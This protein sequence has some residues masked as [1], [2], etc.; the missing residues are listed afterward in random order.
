MTARSLPMPLPC[1]ETHLR[2]QHATSPHRAT[3]SSLSLAPADALIR[4]QAAF[5]VDC[6]LHLRSQWPEPRTAL[7]VGHSMGGVSARLAALDPAFPQGFVAALLTLATPH[8][9]PPWPATVR[10]Q[11]R[12]ASLRRC[13][14]VPCLDSP[15]SWSRG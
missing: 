4:R 9:A 10:L 13:W 11:A 2:N 8:R 3:F 7:V 14:S 12:C 1:D 5:I 15:Q 6:L